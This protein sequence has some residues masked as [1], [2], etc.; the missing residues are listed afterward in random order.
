VDVTGGMLS[1]VQQMVGLVERGHAG[2]VHLISGLQ[3]GA[4]AEVLLDPDA[5][6][7][8]LIVGAER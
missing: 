8:T 7:G 1:K 4:L 2:R 3:P 5:S 6:R